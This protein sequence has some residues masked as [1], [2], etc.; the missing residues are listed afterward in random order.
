MFDHQY[1]LRSILRCPSIPQVLCNILDIP[2]YEN[3]IESLHVMFSLYMDFKDNAHFQA[4]GVE[5][6]ADAKLGMD[7]GGDDVLMMEDK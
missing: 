5:Q 4:G 3:P 2:F 6:G 1:L 7:F